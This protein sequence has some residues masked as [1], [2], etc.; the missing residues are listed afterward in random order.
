[1]LIVVRKTYSAEC[2][3]MQQV[4]VGSTNPV[5]VAAVRA[6]LHRRWPQCVVTGIAVASGVPAQP[7]GDEET[8]AGARERARRA[9]VEWSQADLA[10]GVE[11]GVVHVHGGGL[12]TCA[13]AVAL[14]RTGQEGLGGSLSMPLPD[15]VAQRVLAGEELGVAMDVVA[16]VVGTK[17]G[18]GA[19]GILTDGLVDRQQAY[20][21]LITYALAPWLAPAYFAANTR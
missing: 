8:Q 1:M 5:K 9:L 18:R 20:E 7:F 16:S 13:W 21:P 4:V 11:G 10:V 6:V 19:V 15:A 3:R 12:R 2:V 17:Y 14:D